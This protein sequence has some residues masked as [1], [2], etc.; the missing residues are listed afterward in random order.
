MDQDLPER[1]VL[2]DGFGHHFF[3]LA[4]ASLDVEV[5]PDCFQ[6]VPPGIFLEASTWTS[7]EGSGPPAEA[8]SVSILSPVLAPRRPAEV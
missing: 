5:D 2:P 6:T 7:R 1:R 8:T 4:A 3:E